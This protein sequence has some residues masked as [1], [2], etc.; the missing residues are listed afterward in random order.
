MSI[1]RKEDKPSFKSFS[2]ASN[3]ST[4]IVTSKPR[5]AI[6]LDKPKPI[7]KIPEKKIEKK[8]IASFAD[9]L[10]ECMK[11]GAEMPDTY[12]S[13]CGGR[14][15]NGIIGRMYLKFT[16]NFGHDT[17]TEELKKKEINIPTLDD[18]DCPAC[19][20]HH[21]DHSW[22]AYHLAE[23]H[24][25][26][27]QKII[28]TLRGQTTEKYKEIPSEEPDKLVGQ[29]RIGSIGKPLSAARSLSTNG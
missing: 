16:Y 26:S 29:A 9:I 6:R 2:Q 27:L 11:N 12:R 5:T 17:I 7:E 10:E 18:S 15:P 8:K 22:L 3:F 1:V 21:K 23:D 13:P 24:R 25:Y 4:G 20:E 28:E 19:S 14:C